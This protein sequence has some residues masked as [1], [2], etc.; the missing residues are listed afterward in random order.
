MGFDGFLHRAS[1][2][3]KKKTKMAKKHIFGFFL[4]HVEA[5]C[6]KPSNP[7]KSHQ[8]PTYHHISFHIISSHIPTIKLGSAV[9]AAEAAEAAS[10]V[11]L[12]GFPSW[13]PF[14]EHPPIELEPLTK[15]S[16]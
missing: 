12:H 14:G 16:F 2:C 9:S 8:I 10:T 1:T 3:F 13:N 11:P 7:I 15:G 5:R 6:K 4:K